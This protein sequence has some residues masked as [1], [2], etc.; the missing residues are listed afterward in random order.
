LPG[1]EVLKVAFE[2]DR[3][4]A[5]RWLPPRLTRATPPYAIITVARYRNSPVG[6]FALACQ[7]IGCRAAMFIRAYTLQA[8]ADS[9]EAVAG[10]REV[11]GYPCKPGEVTL[12]RHGRAIEASVSRRGR[13]PVRIEVGDVEP[14]DAASVRLDPVLNARVLPSLEEG[15][16]HDAV[17]IVQIDP[18]YE[19]TDCLRGRAEITY[20]DSSEEDPWSALPVLNVIS[21]TYCVA[22]T[23]LPLARFVMPY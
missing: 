13:T 7:Y 15:K 17:R 9:A 6:P 11:W 18:D 12:D 2:T 10:L 4:A 5:L 23:Q 3:E 19:I 16:R 21:A 20:P 14:V 1:A 22:D 8:V